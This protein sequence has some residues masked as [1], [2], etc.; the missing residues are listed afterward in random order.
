MNAQKFWIGWLKVIALVVSVGGVLFAFHEQ[1]K[2]LGFLDSWIDNVFYNG[3]APASQVQSMRSWMIAVLGAVMASWGIF[4]YFLVR[5]PLSRKEE[6]AWYGIFISCLVWYVID[7]GF[8]A[9]FGAWFNV[10]LN[11]ILFLQFLAPLL[12]LLRNFRVK[13]P[14]LIS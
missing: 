9:R 7:T 13:K 1:L 14:E 2:F 4:L 10:I 6:W 3:N 5:Y 12:F 11:S 8:S